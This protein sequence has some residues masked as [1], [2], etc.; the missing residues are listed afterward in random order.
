METNFGR[1]KYLVKQ[2]L[3]VATETY[4][5]KGSLQ[6]LFNGRWEDTNEMGYVKIEGT[7]NSYRIVDDKNN[8]ITSFKL[9]QLHGC[10]GVCVSFNADVNEKFRKKGVNKLGN[11]LRQEIARVCGYAVLLC[12]DVE[13]NVPQQKT[14]EKE[15]WQKLFAFVNNRTNN[16]VNISIKHL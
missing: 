4:N 10:C 11:K 12:T 9:G 1:V 2:I 6:Q 3:N 8:T 13:G 14:L 15:G 5:S 16:K 7:Y